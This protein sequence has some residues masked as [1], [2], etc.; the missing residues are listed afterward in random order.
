MSPFRQAV[1][2][3]YGMLFRV[4]PDGRIVSIAQVP[5][6]DRATDTPHP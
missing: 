3:T 1:Y 2:A 4:E 5:G 6:P